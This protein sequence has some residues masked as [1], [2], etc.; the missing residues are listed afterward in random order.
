MTHAQL[1]KLPGIVAC[2]GAGRAPSS[3]LQ[4]L[5]EVAAD[6]CPG[7]PSGNC[8]KEATGVAADCAQAGDGDDGSVPL[9]GSHTGRACSPWRCATAAVACGWVL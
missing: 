8:G 6:L 3:P 1:F 9:R 7:S 2:G 5:G 4:R